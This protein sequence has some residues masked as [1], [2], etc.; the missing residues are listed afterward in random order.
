MNFRAMVRRATCFGDHKWIR[1]G[2]G[3]RK[4]HRCDLVQE[5]VYTVRKGKW[6]WRTDDGQ[7]IEMA[8]EVAAAIKEMLN[9][10]GAAK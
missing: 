2:V 1:L 8:A 7:A 3:L 4:C 9:R 5:F 10:K 6:G